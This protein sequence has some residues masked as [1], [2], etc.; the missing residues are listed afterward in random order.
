M[1]SRKCFVDLPSLS[2]FYTLSPLENKV[3]L[4]PRSGTSGGNDNLWS[5][6]KF[7][8]ER[9]GN[10]SRAESQRLGP[11]VGTRP[12]LI[13]LGNLPGMLE[14]VSVGI[15]ALVELNDKIRQPVS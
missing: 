2:L 11:A 3:L 14:R 4:Y 5:I 1:V 8:S 7:F 6:P 13:T 15:W 9:F 10:I 12:L